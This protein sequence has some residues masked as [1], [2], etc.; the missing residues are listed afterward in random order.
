MSA[1]VSLSEP[2]RA[3]LNFVG[4]GDAHVTLQRK[5]FRQLVLTS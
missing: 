5:F 4:A 1:L 2:P 3:I